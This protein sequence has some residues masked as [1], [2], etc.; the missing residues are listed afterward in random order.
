M[1]NE[2]KKLL[3]HVNPVSAYHEFI[4]TRELYETWE[5]LST[6]AS[7]AMRTITGVYTTK[8]E[9]IASQQALYMMLKLGLI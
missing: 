6:T 4:T 1:T 9:I 7:N 5:M 2:Q 8:D 3:I